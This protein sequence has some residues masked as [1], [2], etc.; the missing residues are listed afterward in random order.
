MALGTL[1]Y[2]ARQIP[3]GLFGP[4]DERSAWPQHGGGL[5][6]DAQ[7]RNWIAPGLCS[8]RH[9]IMEPDASNLCKDLEY[10]AESEIWVPRMEHLITLSHRETSP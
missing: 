2:I 8:A 4:K 9:R 10:L 6:N 7:L 5:L 1:L 3:S